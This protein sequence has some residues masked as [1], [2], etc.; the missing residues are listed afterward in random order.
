VKTGIRN[1]AREAA[2]Q[3]LYQ[4]EVGR[5]PATEAAASHREIEQDGAGM[6]ES[7]RRFAEELAVG[8]VANLGSIDPLIEAHARH[9]RLERMAVIDRLILRMAVFEFLF[10]PD[11]PHA[12]AIDEAIE[13]ARTY[14]EEDAVRFVNGVLDGIHHAIAA[15]AAGSTTGSDS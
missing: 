11:T 7:G 5:V 2:L 15:G 14:S 12:V 9:W 3:I 4:W 13:L 1:Q 6:T 8:T 10:R